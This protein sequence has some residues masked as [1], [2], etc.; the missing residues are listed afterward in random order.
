MLRYFLL[1][2]SGVTP[3][4]HRVIAFIVV[5]SALTI[6]GGV[7]SAQ[8]AEFDS[9]H[10]A[11]PQA[12]YGSKNYV[13]TLARMALVKVGIPRPAHEHD[14]IPD[15]L[16]QA[17][18]LARS[19]GFTD[20]EAKIYQYFGYYYWSKKEYEKAINHYDAAAETYQ[21]CGKLA[22]AG[23]SYYDAA[24]VVHK[25][26]PSKQRSLLYW[27]KT[28]AYKKHLLAPKNVEKVYNA[29]TIIGNI[30][31]QLNE[32][33]SAVYYSLQAID[34]SEQH[35]TAY[36]E[37]YTDIIYQYGSQNRFDMAID[38][39]NRLIQRAQI[40]RDSSPE[41][42]GW[43]SLAYL[44]KELN[45]HQSAS[46]YYGKATEIATLI[47]KDFD[48]FQFKVSMLFEQYAARPDAALVDQ[49]C[50]LYEQSKQ[51][52]PC[53]LNLW[54]EGLGTLLARH[55]RT[56]EAYRIFDELLETGKK[57]ENKFDYA[58]ILSQKADLMLK[59]PER[60]REAL[61][62]SRNALQMV[63]QTQEPV[64]FR[65]IADVLARAELLYGN[66]NTAF[67][68]LEASQ[69]Y[70]DSIQQVKFQSLSQLVVQLE[71][72]KSRTALLEKENQVLNAEK[73][74]RQILAVL[75]G[76][77]V[78]SLVVFL[79]L[80]LDRNRI[81]KS[82][83]NLTRQINQRL[84][85]ITQKIQQHSD[86]LALSPNHFG[87]EQPLLQLRRNL[88]VHA[89]NNVQ[90]TNQQLEELEVMVEQQVQLS[91]NYRDNAEKQAEELKVFNYAIGHDLITPLSHIKY[92]IQQLK[93]HTLP[94]H[95]E[96]IGQYL[97]QLDALSDESRMMIEALLRYADVEQHPLV[98]QP[99]NTH[100]LTTQITD[101]ATAVYRDRDLV[102]EVSPDLPTLPGDALLLR[103]VLI[104]LIYNAVKFTQHAHPA[105]I[106]I[107][108]QLMEGQSV[109][110]VEDNGI[111]VPESSLQHIFQLFKTAHNK[112][113]FSGHGIGLAICKKIMQ[114]HGGDVTCRNNPGGGAT[115]VLRFSH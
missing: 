6:Y 85:T 4:I 80:Y 12:T 39:A 115:F 72:Q 109:I 89:N 62:L 101:A 54:S 82:T 23:S 19:Q 81:L 73:H 64:L 34:F 56:E 43:A 112:T 37:A 50:Q 11:L 47:H 71:T 107:Y 44:F 30:Y 2:Q 99:V 55:H 35:K 18:D 27:K 42:W 95:D 9:L 105:I 24:A 48:A 106:R 97:Q 84:Q 70:R 77:L 83:R 10:R 90:L 46:A 57:C 3:F 49:L 66:R 75:M 74:A 1:N 22:H 61:Q 33:D 52:H 88:A 29:L 32:L 36:Q 25:N 86:A 59:K 110:C 63:N 91:K 41:M 16:N 31:R 92:F 108:P 51:Q 96:T 5:F 13:S 53:L 94:L 14:S 113:E 87:R 111:G 17:L 93:E 69:T 67:A 21:K 114:R 38:F 28:I 68:L 26:M 102:F 79:I 20:E 15:W 40:Q 78:V 7:L 103:Q 8:Q 45:D 65:S 100:Q 76:I 98:K 58:K 104:N 60:G